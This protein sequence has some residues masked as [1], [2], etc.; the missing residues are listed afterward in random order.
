MKHTKV[1]SDPAL[2]WALDYLKKNHG[3]NMPDHYT[4]V[5]T[6]WSTV[7]Q[8]TSPQG[9]FYLKQ[10]PPQLYTEARTIAWLRNEGH[11]SIP[12]LVSD[13]ES[14][15]SFL[16]RACGDVPLRDYFHGK[17]DADLLAHGVMQYTNIQRR[18]E[19]SIFEM[20]T[21]N[22]PDWR[23]YQI[24]RL[25]QELIARE[26]LL[27]KDGLSRKEITQLHRASDTC[28]AL[29][30]ALS[31]YHIPETLNHCDFHEN[32]MVI[33]RKTGRISLIDWGEAVI[34]HPFFSLSGCLWNLTY[35]YKIQPGDDIYA[36]LQRRFIL[37]WQDLHS[38]EVLLHALTLSNKLLGVFA[39][40]GYQHM[41]DATMA[42]PRTVQ[43]ERPGSVAGC[44]RS[45]LNAI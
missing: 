43:E 44:L 9:T 23:L 5:E 17:V 6:A 34:S 16:T 29:C 25:Y 20:Q 42:Q 33:E 31:R 37:P 22:L 14:L 45:F 35:F 36:S 24:P 4:V 32:N 8:I 28:R 7:W 41:Y 2:Q 40:L 30:A 27:L 26:D 10:T 3:G 13:N 11:T 19:H 12:V 21:L 39:A 1:E 18:L 15:Y 38:E